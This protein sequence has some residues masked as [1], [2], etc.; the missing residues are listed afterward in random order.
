RARFAEQFREMAE[1]I[2]ALQQEDGLWHPSLLDPKSY[3]IKETSGSS[4]YC[5]ALAWGVNEGVLDRAKFA[6]VATRAW[7]A[8][9][10]CVAPDG[11]L[12]HV[13]PVGLDPRAFDENHTEP[14]GVGA[15]LLA[16]SEIRR[17]K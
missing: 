11:M 15:F 14:F 8:L 4:F 17:M 12:T 10:A 6:P 2:A 3:P 7:K 16:G 5:Y 1:K 9:V 13:Q